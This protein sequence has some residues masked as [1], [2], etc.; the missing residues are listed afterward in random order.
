MK[1]IFISYAV[2]DGS[3]F[4]E[5]LH[6]DLE[7][8]GTDAWLDKR[9]IRDGFNWN[10]EIDR[11]LAEAR[12]VVVVMTP[13][14]VLSLQVEAEWNDALNRYLPVIPLLV[15]SCKV[16]RVLGMLNYINFSK[17]Y[18]AGFAQLVYRLSTLD[19]DHLLYLEETLNGF[20]ATDTPDVFQHKIIAVQAAIERWKGRKDSNDTVKMEP[21][22]TGLSLRQFRRNLEA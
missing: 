18:D 12:A 2:A 16:P 20:L 15:R 7:R 13:G 9:D 6:D 1:H 17:G 11:G 21:R 22:M 10:T 3:S 5:R 4:V 14:S 8:Q 19:R